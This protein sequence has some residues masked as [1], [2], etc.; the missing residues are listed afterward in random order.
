VGFVSA[1]AVACED[2]TLFDLQRKPA[3]RKMVYERAAD[4]TP[5]CTTSRLAPRSENSLQIGFR[6]TKVVATIQC[7]PR[8]RRCFEAHPHPRR[9][10][11]SFHEIG[12]D[13]I[14]KPTLV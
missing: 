9:G 5:V 4:S 13:G 7:Q 12:S 14:E 6:L 3:W 2:M 11:I 8:F 1:M 10:R